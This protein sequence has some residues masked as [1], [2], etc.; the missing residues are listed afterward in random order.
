MMRQLRAW[1]PPGAIRLASCHMPD[2]KRAGHI[3][4]H[5]FAC[6]LRWES[7]MLVL[8]DNR[9]CHH[10]APSDYDGYRREMYRTTIA[11]GVVE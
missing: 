11:G 5:A 7:D 4:S 3:T 1:E 2:A 8:W 10:L 9:L 6:R